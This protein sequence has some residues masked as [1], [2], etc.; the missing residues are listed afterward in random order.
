MGVDNTVALVVINVGQ[1]EEFEEAAFASA[2]LTDDIDVAGAV[3]AGEA[4]LVIDAAK[5]RETEG[6]DIFVV[7]RATGEDG[8]FGRRL[9]GASGGPDDVG[10]LDGSVGKVKNRGELTDIEDKT[11]VGELAEFIDV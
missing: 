6:G 10:G 8:E 4:E 3:A 11:R 9:G 2:G 5:V 1:S 7:G